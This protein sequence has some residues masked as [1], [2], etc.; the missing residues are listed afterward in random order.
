MTLLQCLIDLN[1]SAPFTPL[2][3][4]IAEGMGK[5]TKKCFTKLTEMLADRRA[6]LKNTVTKLMQYRLSVSL[7]HSAILC[8]RGTK[9]RPQQ[10]LGEVQYTDTEADARVELLSTSTKE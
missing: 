9:N 8:M 10:P 3:F 6:Q 5:C 7:L 2:L 4:T 1:E